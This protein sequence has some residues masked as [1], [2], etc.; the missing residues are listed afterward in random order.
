MTYFDLRRGA[1]LLM[2]LAVASAC[3]DPTGPGPEPITELPRQLTSVEKALID[4]S[5][6]FGLELMREVTS[7][8]EG[9][10]VVISPLSA[11]MALGMT[12]N[13]AAGSTFEAMRSTLG[14]GGLTQAEINTAYH[15]L[16]ELLRGLDETVEFSV[17][18]SVWSRE[19]FPFHDVF[20]QAV[21]AAF[22]AHLE[23]RDFADP[24]TL[25]AINGWVSDETRGYIP[26]LLDSIDPQMV[27][28]LVNAIYFDGS[29]TTRFD[30]GETVAAEFRR[31]DGSRVTVD[32][33][34]LRDHTV[35]T[36]RTEDFTAAELTYGGG[37]FGM[38][39]VVPEGENTARDLVAGM[40]AGWWDALSGG[41]AESELARISL[42]RFTLSYGTT[43]NEALKAMGMEVA[44]SEMEADFTNLSPQGEWL[45]IDEVRQKTFIEV[46]EAGTRAAAATSV[47][48]G[49][50]SLPPMLVADRPFFFAIRERLSGTLVF[51]GLVGD[52][53]AEE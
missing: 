46:D 53:T 21:S 29:W 23:T 10:N 30:R 14:Y 41:L 45:Y 50:T 18:N 42:P 8:E 6:G 43:M 47:G 27:M 52:P 28:F 37:A 40:D 24:A 39:I 22:D 4:A 7:G 35:P 48:I 19:G 31:G 12:L 13:G 32:M 25:D 49:V 1:V 16:L 2:T 51:T 5:N 36:F 44:F 38:V 11:S 15:D 33:M 9:A 26:R 3:N 34:T 20:Y 17:A